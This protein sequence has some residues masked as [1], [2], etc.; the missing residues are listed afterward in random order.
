MAVIIQAAIGLLLFLLM[1]GAAGLL[2]FAGAAAVYLL[3][4]AVAGNFIS[5]KN[6]RL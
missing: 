4:M 2:Y 6:R 3:I 5:P 1:F